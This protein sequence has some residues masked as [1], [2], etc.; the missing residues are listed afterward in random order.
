MLTNGAPQPRRFQPVVSAGVRTLNGIAL[1]HSKRG[2]VV[3]RGSQEQIVRAFP[4][5]VL[6]ASFKPTG[7][8]ANGRIDPRIMKPRASEPPRRLRT[9]NAPMAR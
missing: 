6:Q 5:V 4:F 2:D 9:L 1:A 7:L 3:S 8:Y